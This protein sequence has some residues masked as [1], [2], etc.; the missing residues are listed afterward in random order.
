MQGDWPTDLFEQHKARFHG[1]LGPRL[2]TDIKPLQAQISAKKHPWNIFS[3]LTLI[4]GGAGTVGTANMWEQG[5]IPAIIATAASFLGVNSVARKKNRKLRAAKAELGRYMQDAIGLS[6]S[7]VS[8]SHQYVLQTFSQAGFLGRFD[9]I[10][11]LVGLAPNGAQQPQSIG[12]KL[13]RTET[14]TY[15]DSEGRTRTRQR[16]VKVFEGLMLEMDISDFDTDNRT[17]ITSR[18]TYRFSGPFDRI[19]NGKRHKMDKIK[20]ASLEFNKYYKVRTDDSTLGHLFLDPERVMRFINLQADLRQALGTKRVAISILITKG[21]AW[22]ALETGGL[23][24]IDSFSSEP[25]KL[26]HEVGKIIGQAALP[27]MI[28]EHLEWPSPMSY[29]WQDYVLDT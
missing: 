12:T 15:T 14:E 17:L 3:V 6:L 21:R 2:E 18:R 26:D 4:G 16:I 25:E 5:V 24:T 7:N 27:H 20:T 22:I 13:T 9:R 19:K 28:A 8:Q 11:Y 1:T 29:A 10:H 23:P